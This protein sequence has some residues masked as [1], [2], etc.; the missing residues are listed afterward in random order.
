[1]LK[2][3][4][5]FATFNDAFELK[6]R[7]IAFRFG[8]IFVRNFRSADEAAKYGM[9]ETTPLV[10]Q[11]E[12]MF[13]KYLNENN[14]SSIE[15]GPIVCDRANP[16]LFQW[17]PLTIDFD[18]NGAMADK[19]NC[20]CG[21]TNDKKVCNQCWE[22]FMVPAMNTIHSVL[23][24][25]FKFKSV[26]TL[27]SGRR[28]FHVYVLDAEVWSYSQQQR[29]AIFA[30]FNGVDIDKQ[31]CSLGHLVKAPLIIHP[32]TQMRAIPIDNTFRPEN[33]PQNLDLKSCIELIEEKLRDGRNT[34]PVFGRKEKSKE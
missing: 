23:E 32:A 1:M 22:Q 16:K 34:G 14:P 3:W 7:V 18:M 10:F 5:A 29:E 13:E 17:A 26:L 27:F 30:Q 19:R 25:I 2:L 20:K 4:C 33:Y 8:D 11:N 31:A 15:F 9:E 12:L 21:P 6:N 28:G 24:K